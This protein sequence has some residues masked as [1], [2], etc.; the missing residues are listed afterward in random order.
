LP[1]ATIIPAMLGV[2]Q[3]LTLVCVALLVQAAPV[4][5]R[6]VPLVCNGHAQLCD[7]S[8]GNVTY[9][10]S[11]DS[12]SID[13]DFLDLAANQ[14]VSVSAQLDLGVR[15]LQ[16]QSHL[17]NGALELCHTSCDLLDGGSLVNWLTTIVTWLTANPHEVVTL[18][19]TNNDD[20]DVGQYWAPAFQESG[21]D[22]LVYTP[23]HVPMLRSEWPTLRELISANHRV[24]VFMDTLAN[25]TEVPYIL[26][27]LDHM[28]ETPF[29]VTDSSFP[30][31]VQNVHGSPLQKLATLNHFLDVSIFGILIPDRASASVTNSVG[32]IMSQAKAC[33]GLGDNAL[34]THILLDFVD[35]GQAIAAGNML[36]G[37]TAS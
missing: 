30:C 21:M 12:Y 29:D 13:G 9:I 27:E 32:S 7:R 37:L 1:P 20:V 5:K 15:F 35:E 18:L 33:V 4:E 17:K 34:P 8:Y 36:N 25:V 28:W 6:L 2:L 19:V 16:A 23:P 22:E 11:H 10:G 31:S 3:S 14:R 24:V 26:P